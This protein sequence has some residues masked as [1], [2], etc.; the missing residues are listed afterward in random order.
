MKMYIMRVFFLVFARD[1]ECVDEKIQELESLHFP[2]VVIC[3]KDLGHPNVVYRKC[4]GKYDA[5]NFGF[6]FVPKDTE[7]VVLNDVDTEIHNVEAAMRSM[8]SKD[9]AIV[10]AKVVVKE[11]PQKLFYQFLDSIRRRFPIIASG[12]L[13]F[14]RY[15][16]LMKVLP[17]EP[18][19]AEDSYILFK[20]LELRN[21]AVFSEDCFVETERTKNPQQEEYYKRRTVTGLYQALGYTK[22]PYLV[23]FFFILLPFACPLLLISGK[24]GYYWVKGILGG[25]ADYLRGDRAGLWQQTYAP[26]HSL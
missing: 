4:R 14:I 20:T 5:I 3:G 6:E 17:M 25:W 15:D 19:K 13:L 10:F 8:G 21:K 11:G 18:C 1:E 24:K 22:P 2:Y 12:E 26:P 7:I 23:R 16:V 9:V